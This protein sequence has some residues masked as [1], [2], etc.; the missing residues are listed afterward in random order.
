M[1][2]R[3]R[4]PRCTYCN[5]PGLG[6]P[7]LCRQHFEDVYYGGNDEDDDDPIMDLFDDFL[8]HPRVQGWVDDFRRRFDDFVGRNLDHPSRSPHYRG[9]TSGFSD[10]PPGQRRAPGNGHREPPEP[11][12][13]LGEDPRVVLGFAPGST[14]TAP[15]IKKRQRELAIILHPDK[16]GSDAAMQRINQAAEALLSQL[17]R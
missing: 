11:P 16:G 1:P 7:P 4:L 5:R 8:E 17:R 10:L 6:D 13:A 12:P 14:P 9:P 2:R 3:R 15:E